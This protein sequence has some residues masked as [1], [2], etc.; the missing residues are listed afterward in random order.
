MKVLR[1]IFLF[2]IAHTHKRTAAVAKVYESVL[3]DDK[4]KS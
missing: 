3:L 2:Y 4:W 1:E